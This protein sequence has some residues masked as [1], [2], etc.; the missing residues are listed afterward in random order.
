[1]NWNDITCK[2]WL[3]LFKF[4]KTGVRFTKVKTLAILVFDWPFFDGK[5]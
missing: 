5:L 3:V 4:K 1:M 2:Q